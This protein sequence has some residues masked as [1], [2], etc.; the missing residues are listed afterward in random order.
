MMDFFAT[1]PKGLEYLLRDE[2]VGQGAD[3]VHEALAGVHF[4]GDLEAGYRACLESRLASR[5]LLPLHTFAAGDQDALYRG[6][7]DID[8]SAH[9]GAEGSLAVDAVIARSAIQ[10]SRY[11]AQVV[12]DAMV[13]QFRTE[14]GERPSVALQRPDIRLHLLLRRDKA[15][16]SLDLSGEPLHRRGCRVAQGGAPL[17]ENLAAAMLLRA[18]WMEQYRQ[19]GVLLDPMCGAA[20]LLIEGAWMAADVAPGL[21]RDYFGFLAWRGHDVALW[22]RLHERASQR[23]KIGLQQLRTVFYGRDN[24]AQ[25]LAAARRNAVAAGV[26]GFVH[27][28]R[29]DVAHLQ[30]PD[31]ASTGLLLS[32]PPYGERL[33]NIEQARV[34]YRIL[35]ERLRDAFSGWRASVLVADP[36]AAHD[37]GLRVDRRHQLYNGA[38]E[39]SLLHFDIHPRSAQPTSKPLSEGAQMVANRLR[40]NLA[41]LRKWLQCENIHCFRVYDADLPEY[42]AAIDVY[43]GRV[44]DDQGIASGEVQRWLH[45]QEYQAPA[46]VDPLKA[47]QRFGDLLHAAGEALEVPRERVAVKTRVRGRIGDRYNSKH[48]PGGLIEV[49]EAGLYFRVNLF[50][51]LDTGLFLDHRLIRTQLRELAPER[52][53]LNLFAYTATASAYAAIGGARATLSVDLSATYLQWASWNLARNG[54]TGSRHRLEQADVP[55]W[56]LRQAGHFGLIYVDPPTF[57]NSKRTGDFNIQRDHVDL[58]KRCGDLLESDGVLVF[59]NHFRRF[60]LD[61]TALEAVFSIEDGTKTSIPSDFARRSGIHGCWLL[62]PR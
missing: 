55:R 26:A 28:Q 45:I 24:D 18:G 32:N 41:K 59:S 12:K 4:R 27:L 6:V 7:R 29:G 48:H 53:M 49:E 11:A 19:G 30:R 22:A 50:E 25:A 62:R 35:G 16:L 43:A 14:V 9:L 61:R 5:V 21:Q 37:L 60:K 47:R 40:K 33:G 51:F 31:G 20:T 36:Q 56:L 52:K 8:W 13:D 34:L 39:C 15:Q 46:T 58:L 17:K 23:A 10:H 2:L 1:C 44:L 38:I 3:D 42:S 54:F 57:S